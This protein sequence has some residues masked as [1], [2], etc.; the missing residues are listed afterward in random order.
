MHSKFTHD[1]SSTDSRESEEQDQDSK[2][3]IQDT[4]GLHQEQVKGTRATA[5]RR[6]EERTGGTTVLL[7]KDVRRKE[8]P[9]LAVETQSPPHRQGSD[10]CR[11]DVNHQLH[12]ES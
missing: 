9:E 12:A 3:I 10:R 1:R 6:K 4:V 5:A 2:D 8:Q 11:Q 7:K